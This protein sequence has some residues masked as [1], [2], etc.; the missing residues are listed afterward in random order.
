MKKSILASSFI[1]AIIVSAPILADKFN[2]EV[3]GEYETWS[4]GI[5][6]QSTALL[7]GAGLAYHQDKMFYGGGFVLGNYDMDSDTGKDLKRMDVDLVAGYRLDHMWSA[8]A[9][10]R[11][12]QMNYTSQS[13]TSDFDENTHGLGGGIALNQVIDAQWVAFGSAAL[14]LLSTETEYKD[15]SLDSDPGIGFSIGVEGGALYRIN[16]TTNTALR[17]KYQTTRINYDDSGVE[18]PHSYVRFGVSLNHS[19]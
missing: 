9:G 15:S 1:V 16:K 17:I 18:W 13:G 7:Y 12:N 3:K 6:G 8:F 5:G 19:F 10:Y 14:S 2:A 11:F 4:S